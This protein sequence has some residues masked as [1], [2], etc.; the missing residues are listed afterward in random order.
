M[1]LREIPHDR[2][3]LLDFAADASL[4][5]DEAAARLTRFGR[6]Q[7]FERSEPA[8]R[9]LMREALRDPMLAFL[10]AT[11]G[12]YALVGE[13]AEAWTLLAATVP[14][15]AM[16]AFLHRR[17]RASLEGLASRLAARATIR[18][19]GQWVERASETLVPGDRVRIRPGENLPADGVV[20]AGRDI[21]IDESTLSGESA[22][23]RKRIFEAA[24]AKRRA[25]REDG[26]ALSVDANRWAMAGTRLLAGEAE[27][28]V[29]F[30]G[31]ETLYGEI[32]R[33]SRL[34]GRTRTL[35]Q[36]AV[37]RLVRGLVVAASLLCMLLA[38]VR[39]RQG[40]GWSDALV[41]AL[42]LA[43]AALP[44][45]FPV[46]LAVFLGLGAHRLA[47]RKALVSRATA[48]ENVG[49]IDCICSDKTGTITQ[50]ELT[51][52]HVHSP[53]QDAEA[54][55]GEHIVLAARADSGDPLDEAIFAAASARGWVLT[56]PEIDGPGPERLMTFPFTEDRRRETAVVRLADG[57]LL[58]VTKGAPELVLSLCEIDGREHAR[59]ETRIADW[60]SEGHK[61]I[62]CASCVM[63]TVDWDRREPGT[64]MTFD[65]LLA[66]EDPVRSEVADAVAQCREDGID[67]VMVTGDHA[68]TA[69]A[70]ARQIGLG[71]MQ[72]RI[73]SGVELD[74]LLANSGP[75][76]LTGLDVV[77][78]ALPAQK[79]ALV[80]ALQA[81]GRLVAVTGDGVNDVPALQA[82]DVGVAVGGRAS[83][84]AR[85]A[86]AIV[87]L[88]DS[89]AT[90]VSAIAEGRQLFWNL[91]LAFRYLLMIHI[92]LVLSA[93]LI[94]LAGYPLL[95]QPIHIVWLELVIHPSA[96]LAF[97][98]LPVRGRLSATRR[99][100]GSSVFSLRET[101]GIGAVGL[102]LAGVIGWG[103]VD[104]LGMKS[105]V[106]HGRAFCL[107]ALS[108]ASASIVAGLSRFGTRAS[109]WVAF[110]T[111]A[112]AIL[113][114]QTSSLAERLHVAPL[115]VA[116][117][118][119]AALCGAIAAAPSGFERLFAPPTVAR[120]RTA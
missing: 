119:L 90:V 79:L 3:A 51:L 108:F 77:V 20:V 59:L 72:P 42:T 6:N 54:R 45:E 25:G 22:P 56:R 33:S 49:R 65:G 5:S 41:S 112:T 100:V 87:L 23:V 66:F 19:D 103:F 86:A 64:G 18:R 7:V 57:S 106:E 107:A 29:V 76:A 96:V 13:R 93:V 118:G 101:I 111:V 104:G 15:V 38:V 48:V 36:Q 40:F 28:C 62:A 61:V 84:S 35:L 60:A 14:L 47:R 10:A 83:R 16:D 50:G 94:P 26:I 102:V 63:T 71:G 53:G 88:D 2:I 27:V 69:A 95:F 75:A 114:I 109:R 85:E 68:A 91:R 81:T 97:Q 34:G 21:Q 98:A 110:G 73:L 78:R 1:I 89:F 30:T 17:T 43:V 115:H 67:V 82:A 44:E 31:K 8:W 9:A 39:L 120:R 80:R 58:A 105:W 52:T 117:W 92:P 46:I 55:L 37:A 113:L 32:V 4:A 116:D 11:S 99:P 70:V 24:G 74:A 12:L